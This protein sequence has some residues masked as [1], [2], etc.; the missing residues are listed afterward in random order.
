MADRQRG[1]SAELDDERQEDAGWSSIFPS[2]QVDEDDEASEEELEEE[3]DPVTALFDRLMGS[4]HALS[5]GQITQMWEGCRAQREHLLGP[6]R[7]AKELMRR[8]VVAL[9]GSES[10]FEAKTA[11]GTIP[12]W[13]RKGWE[14]LL[15]G[16][17][18]DKVLGTMIAE[19]MALKQRSRADSTTRRSMTA[20]ES[21]PRPSRSES[22]VP[23][24]RTTILQHH[25]RADEGQTLTGF[26]FATRPG[27]APVPIPP[28][29][30]E[31]TKAP[32]KLRAYDLMRT[33]ARHIMIN[34]NTSQVMYY[35]DWRI[36]FLLGVQSTA[37]PTL[38]RNED[39]ARSYATLNMN[40][41]I[42]IGSDEAGLRLAVK[43]MAA[44]ALERKIRINYE[45]SELHAATDSVAAAL[46][47][48]NNLPSIEADRLM[49][50]LYT[51]PH[52]SV[53][54]TVSGP[55]S[56]LHVWFLP[57]TP[58]AEGTEGTCHQRTS[59]PQQ[60]ANATHGRSCGKPPSLSRVGRKPRSDGA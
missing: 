28:L 19:L 36:V 32:E 17:H 21:I 49:A 51:G 44:M 7:T 35:G 50:R 2:E 13:A 1:P 4:L 27:F 41:P 18:S 42:N 43:W 25:A 15:A 34:R 45:V 54:T 57:S 8:A 24:G 60:D 20:V 9:G 46:C 26:A 14:E 48:K 5:E 3:Q 38:M 12:P 55:I 58:K 29:T 6:E 30:D 40:N 33:V 47:G 56:G 53:E 10:V 52:T 37:V 11:D 31:V 39:E 16:E 22:A 59:A 23:A